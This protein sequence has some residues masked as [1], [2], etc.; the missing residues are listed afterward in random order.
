MHDKLYIY[1]LDGW[2]SKETC[3]RTSKNHDL[4]LN[5]ILNDDPIDVDD[6]T[7]RIPLHNH[8]GCVQK[9]WYY[10]GTRVCPKDHD[11]IMVL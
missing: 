8:H 11:N 7:P 3:P 5:T 10:H 1:K 4:A 6:L 9:E 2:G